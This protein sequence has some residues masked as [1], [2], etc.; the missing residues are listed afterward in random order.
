M[1]QRLRTRIRRFAKQTIGFL[2][3]LISIVERLIVVLVGF[4]GLWFGFRLLLGRSATDLLIAMSQNWKA[5]LILLIP[6]FY[7]TI[8]KFLEEVEEAYG[9]KRHSKKGQ[10]EQQESR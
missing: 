4:G 2:D 9:M 3:L 1:T 8:R 6:L 5:F 7:Q 10:P